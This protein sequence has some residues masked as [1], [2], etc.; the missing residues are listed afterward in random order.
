MT[1]TAGVSFVEIV[2]WHFIVK[3]TNQ[4]VFFYFR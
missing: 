2:I 4:T 3:P 1:Y